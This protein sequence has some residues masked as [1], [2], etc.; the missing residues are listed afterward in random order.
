MAL[1]IWDLCSSINVAEGDE[2]ANKSTGRIYT[3]GKRGKPPGWVKWNLITRTDAPTPVSR[4][5]PSSKEGGRKS[6]KREQC[7][8]APEVTA[9]DFINKMVSLR[10]EFVKALHCCSYINKSFGGLSVDLN[11]LFASIADQ[12][13]CKACNGEYVN[14]KGYDLVCEGKKISNKGLQQMFCITLPKTKNVI[15][16]NKIR[17]HDSEDTDHAAKAENIDY[18][19]IF[20]VQTG[21]NLSVSIARKDDVKEFF[22]EKQNTV[23]ASVPF[24][25]QFFIVHPSE[26]LSMENSGYVTE[27]VDMNFKLSN[28]KNLI[29]SITSTTWEKTTKVVK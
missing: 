27:D 2:I 17:K 14:V 19:Y 20:L 21:E 4:A 24:A 10:E 3:V 29:P 9:D 23:E 26:K 6:S 7:T 13:I 28:L 15:I 8:A 12:F 25:R 22:K 11:S 5:K 16:A 1:I 18:D